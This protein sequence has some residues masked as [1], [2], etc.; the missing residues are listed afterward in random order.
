MSWLGSFTPLLDI[1]SD[2]FRLLARAGLCSVKNPHRVISFHV[3]VRAIFSR[4]WV[5]LHPPTEIRTQIVNPI[6]KLFW[7]S[8]DLLDPSQKGQNRHL[9]KLCSVVDIFFLFFQELGLVTGTPVGTS[10]IDAHAGGVGVMESVPESET[11]G[12]T[13]SLNPLHINALCLLKYSCFLL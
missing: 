3:W 7:A 8:F 1:P 12:Y 9:Y 13:S 6:K 10:L 5:D 2:L 4:T 11:N